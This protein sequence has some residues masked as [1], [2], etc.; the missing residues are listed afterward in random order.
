M[1]NRKTGRNYIDIDW[2]KVDMML[3]AGIAGTSIAD[4]L[5]IDRRTLYRAVRR[6]YKC[7][8][9]TY[10]AQKR[11]TGLDMLRLKQHEI[12]MRGNVSMLIW[13]GKQYLDQ[14]DTRQEDNYDYG[15][16]INFISDLKK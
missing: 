8:F 15:K 4:S 11:A 10:Q 7:T 9:G 12:A 3:Q 6:E 2:K 1:P 5:G 13:L 14:Q 16:I